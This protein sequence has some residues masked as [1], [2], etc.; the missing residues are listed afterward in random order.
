MINSIQDDRLLSKT[1]IHHAFYGRNGGV[2]KKSYSSL[3][4]SLTTEDDLSNVIENR[5]LVAEDFRVPVEQLVTCKQIHSSDVII[6]NKPWSVEDSPEADALVTKE[7]GIALGV[8]TADCVPLLLADEKA[9]VIGA[10]HAGWRGASKGI[11][12]ESIKAM[13]ELGAS[14]E[15]IIGAIGPAIWQ[16]DYEID[17]QTMMVFTDSD[18][19]SR[20]FFVESD[21]SGHF[22]FDLPA[23]V[24]GVVLGEGARECGLSP[25]ST[26]MNGDYFSCRRNAH[27]N[28]GPHGAQISLIMIG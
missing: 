11:I 25:V 4:C 17:A 6:V 9:G 18:V 13:V 12:Q 14:K 27:N 7:K 22:M 15:N 23:F 24:R 2:S 16:D 28:S 19:N 3:N 20:R 26:Y 21:K 1:T 5:K 10:V 8:V